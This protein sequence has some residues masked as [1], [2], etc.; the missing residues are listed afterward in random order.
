MRH[1]SSPSTPL[2]SASKSPYASFFDLENVLRCGCTLDVEPSDHGAEH[3]SL[4]AQ[5]L[6]QALHD[7]DSYDDDDA[8]HMESARDYVE[9]VSKQLATMNDSEQRDTWD[10]PKKYSRQVSDDSQT[11]IT[12]V[13][14]LSTNSNST[15]H[16]T[17]F[18]SL[19]HAASDSTQET[20][21]ISD[22]E[23][24][25]SEEPREDFVAQPVSILR[26]KEKLGAI[27]PSNGRNV[28]FCATT[29]FPDPNEVPQKRK[30]VRRIKAKKKKELQ[31]FVPADEE[32][33]QELRRL[34]RRAQQNQ[35]AYLTDD[36]R[37]PSSE[38]LMP[39]ES[40]YVFRWRN[41]EPNEQQQ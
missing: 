31:V 13:F 17:S 26:R 19:K 4:A 33:P 10:K 12:T 20:A 28:T 21:A 24:T 37:S 25:L 22:D 36:M 35:Y 2:S 5:P 1:S 34:E 11:S 7:E 14:R 32:L 9:R 30:R 39:S 3:E 40:F 15:I 16:T 18:P 41:K 23:T 6:R 27:L 8:L 29:V 38:I